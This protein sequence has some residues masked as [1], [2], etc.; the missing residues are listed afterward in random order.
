ENKYPS[1]FSIYLG[2][3]ANTRYE[4]YKVRMILQKQPGLD[5]VPKGFAE[6]PPGQ[7]VPKSL[8]EDITTSPDFPTE[9]IDILGTQLLN[10]QPVA[11]V[12]QGG[13]GKLVP[14]ANITTGNFVSNDPLF[15]PSVSIPKPNARP[16][17]EINSTDLSLFFPKGVRD[18]K[19]LTGVY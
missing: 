5:E 9:A 18:F 19:K 13:D 15:K 12:K 6:I 11:E 17:V 14:S 16:E 4:R 1:R 8:I 7:T 10:G 2:G 3:K